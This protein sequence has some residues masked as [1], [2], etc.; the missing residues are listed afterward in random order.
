MHEANLLSGCTSELMETSSCEDM[1]LKLVLLHSEGR[2]LHKLHNMYF[3]PDIIRVIK[4]RR[5]RW[6]VHIA[7]MGN[8]TNAYRIL[9]GKCEWNRPLGRKGQIWKDNIKTD[10]KEIIYRSVKCI[11]L[12]LERVQ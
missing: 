5:M 3:S 1:C 10:L 7:H 8:T 12:A 4:S 9:V 6:L 2:K 11:H